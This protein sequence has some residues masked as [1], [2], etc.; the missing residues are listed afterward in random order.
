MFKMFKE[1]TVY[2]NNFSSKCLIDLLIFKFKL[3]VYHLFFIGKN[4]CNLCLFLIV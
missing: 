2:A 3:N 4:V 1:L